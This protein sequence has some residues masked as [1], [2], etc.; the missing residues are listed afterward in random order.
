M[1]VVSYY[2]VSGLIALNDQRFQR[3]SPIILFGVKRI[4][5]HISILF[6]GLSYLSL[7]SIVTYVHL[8]IYLA[9]KQ[10]K[11]RAKING[12]LKNKNSQKLRCGEFFSQCLV[13]DR[14]LI[15]NE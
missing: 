10:I 2:S 5:P 3:E 9:G 13:F 4:P 1:H 8:R 6:D 12:A 15:F 7:T 11:Q 14:I